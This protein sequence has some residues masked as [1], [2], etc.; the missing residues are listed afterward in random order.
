MVTFLCKEPA[1]CTI[2]EQRPVLYVPLTYT[3]MLH[4]IESTLSCNA[5]T[6]LACCTNVHLRTGMLHILFSF[7]VHTPIPINTEHCPFAVLSC[8][9]CS[10]IRDVCRRVVS[11]FVVGGIISWGLIS[12]SLFCCCIEWSSYK[13]IVVP[14]PQ[15]LYLL[16]QTVVGIQTGR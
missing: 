6:I 11:L 10:P 1:G 15:R 16:V 8:L 5:S 2:V 14:R 13:Y 3:G 12:Y 7:G 9:L 4:G